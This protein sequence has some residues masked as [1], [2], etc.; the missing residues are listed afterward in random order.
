[1]AKKEYTLFT[2]RTEKGDEVQ[3]PAKGYVRI[4]AAGAGIA[5]CHGMK[6]NE[7]KTSGVG[8]SITSSTPLSVKGGE[9]LVFRDAQ[10]MDRV[11]LEERP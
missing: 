2:D 9:W 1:M 8:F 6:F 5:N 3:I 7:R 4:E 10:N 11:Y